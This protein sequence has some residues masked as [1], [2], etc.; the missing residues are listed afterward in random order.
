MNVAAEALRNVGKKGVKES[1][2]IIGL[3]VCVIRE[4]NMI[5]QSSISHSRVL[6]TSRL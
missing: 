2:L 4:M 1:V 3:V 5:G 6:D